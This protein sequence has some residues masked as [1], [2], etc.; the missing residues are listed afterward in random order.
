MCSPATERTRETRTR[1]RWPPV[2]VVAV[3]RHAADVCLSWPRGVCVGARGRESE[4]SVCRR[5]TWPSS[6]AAC[7]CVRV[8]K[9]ARLAVLLTSVYA[10]CRCLIVCVEERAGGRERQ[11]E[12]VSPPHL[13]PLPRPPSLAPKNPRK[14]TPTRPHFQQRTTYFDTPP[15]DP[16]S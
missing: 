4:T 14:Q 2:Q 9:G 13:S 1:A 5:P 10:W 7:E 12:V 8:S 3:D 15:T 11:Q 6:R 16:Y